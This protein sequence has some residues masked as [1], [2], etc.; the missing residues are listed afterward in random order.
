[1]KRWLPWTIALLVSGCANYATDPFV[2]PGGA[3]WRDEAVQELVK[4][5]IRGVAYDVAADVLYVST[6]TKAAYGCDLLR[7]DVGARSASALPLDPAYGYLNP[8]YSP[9]EP[10]RLYAVRTSRSARPS[11]DRVQQQLVAIDLTTRAETVLDT[12]RD[13]DRFERLFALGGGRLAVQRS[14]KTAPSVKCRGD[15]CTD[16][17]T[18]D[19]YAADRRTEAYDAAASWPGYNTIDMAPVGPAGVFTGFIFGDRTAN[20]QRFFVLEPS[21]A[22]FRRFETQAAMFDYLATTYG[23]DRLQPSAPLDPNMRLA[24]RLLADI[25]SDAATASFLQ[26]Q[27]YRPGAVVYV[28]KTRRAGNLVLKIGFVDSDDG[29]PKLRRTVEVELPR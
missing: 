19:L 17:L 10:D 12:T 1:M 29:A 9:D 14:Y 6:C 3:V 11:N 23:K 25:S 16:A 26:G 20:P 21:T 27:V 2:P 4:P 28:L 13:G 24:R 18:V 7:I 22:S 8:A 5:L 15:F